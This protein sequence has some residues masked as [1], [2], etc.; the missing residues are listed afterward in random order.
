MDKT[1][2]TVGVIIVLLVSG[3][4]Y[5]VS[6]DTAKDYQVYN[7]DDLGIGMLCWKLSKPNAENFSTRCYWNISASTRY[8]NCKSGWNLYEEE[9]IGEEYIEPQPNADFL[10]FS[11]FTRVII[12]DGNKT[13]KVCI[14]IHGVIKTCFNPINKTNPIAEIKTF[15]EDYLARVELR[16]KINKQKP[17]NLIIEKQVING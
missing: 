5:F 15:E 13:E 16:K 14:E 8:K 11:N 12:K 10:E 9:I 6:E 1:E 7:C 3:I 17:Q 2:L 4:S